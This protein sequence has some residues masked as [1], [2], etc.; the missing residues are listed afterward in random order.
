MDDLLAKSSSCGQIKEMRK[1]VCVD[2][3]EDAVLALSFPFWC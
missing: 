3:V 2:G 1:M